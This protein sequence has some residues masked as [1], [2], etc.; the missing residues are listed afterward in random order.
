MTKIISNNSGMEAETILKNAA[1]PKS[2]MSR[3]NNKF[4]II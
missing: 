1:S 3:G 2:Q 4:S